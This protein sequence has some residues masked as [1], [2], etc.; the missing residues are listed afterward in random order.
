MENLGTSLGAK[1]NLQKLIMD[2]ILKATSYFNKRLPEPGLAKIAP[3]SK[4]GLIELSQLRNMQ[5]L[6]HENGV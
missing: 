5:E 4:N 1:I 6:S 2:E 3:M